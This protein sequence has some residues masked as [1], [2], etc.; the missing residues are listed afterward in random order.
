[1]FYVLTPVWPGCFWTLSHELPFKVKLLS[2]YNRAETS[3]QPGEHLSTHVGTLPSHLGH[4]TTMTP[5]MGPYQ[6][7]SMGLCW[8][9]EPEQEA[10]MNP[11]SA[12]QV[13]TRALGLIMAWMDEA[14]HLESV[15]CLGR[16]SMDIWTRSIW[17]GTSKSP[18]RRA[19]VVFREE[20][21]S[22]KLG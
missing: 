13:P 15:A 12:V 19:V 18:T 8:T 17:S 10:A 9:Q 5:L 4:G 16:S 3:L 14:Q 11:T 22:P 7:A 21:P 20:P 1:M 6:L 2:P